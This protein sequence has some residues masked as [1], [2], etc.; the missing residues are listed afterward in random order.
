MKSQLK[1]YFIWIPGPG[2]LW[3]AKIYFNIKYLFLGILKGVVQ[4][5]RVNRWEKRSKSTAG[6]ATLPVSPIITGLPPMLRHLCFVTVL[7]P[8]RNYQC[9]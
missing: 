9:D 6:F 5:L 1:T 4:N 7:L 2:R 8:L 3:I